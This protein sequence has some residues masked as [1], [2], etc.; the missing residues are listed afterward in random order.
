MGCEICEKSV[1]KD[2]RQCKIAQRK[3]FK[4]IYFAPCGMNFNSNKSNVRGSN[5]TAPKNRK[6]RK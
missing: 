1:P 3:P 5:Y 4:G 2:F 6:K